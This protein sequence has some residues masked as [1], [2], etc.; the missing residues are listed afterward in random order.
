[1]P[2]QS[3][4]NEAMSTAE[5]GRKGGQLVR[6]LIEKGKRAETGGKSDEFREQLPNQGAH[7][8]QQ[9]SESRSSRGSQ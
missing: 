2:N 7:R 8:D 4:N 9:G 3:N 1:M 5:A 6:E